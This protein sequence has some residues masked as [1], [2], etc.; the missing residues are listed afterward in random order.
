MESVEKLPLSSVPEILSPR[1]KEKE[2][3]PG[4]GGS[5]ETRWQKRL[6]PFMVV[7]L[8]LVMLF[9]FTASAFQLYYLHQRIERSPELD[10]NP[11]LGILESN[12]AG[13]SEKD[14]LEIGR[15]KTL[16]I[17]EGNALQRRYHQANTL[18]MS[19]IWTAYLGFVTGMILAL[20]GAT[21]ILGK[22]RESESQV[23]AGSQ[24]WK[25]S[26]TTASPGLVLALLGTI[27]MITTMV[28]HYEIKVSDGQLYT[29]G[30]DG[31]ANRE[32]QDQAD[33]LPPPATFP[34]ESEDEVIPTKDAKAKDEKAV[35]SQPKDNSTR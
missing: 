17:L 24:L 25:F 8:S 21:F 23:D 35:E 32:R 4:R 1:L 28:S 33:A 9:F 3:R 6:L 14:K 5:R 19:R 2:K 11:A 7:V 12:P 34:A 20:V 15:W 26:I 30:W 31:A 10:L 27:L 29:A 22:L 18:L 16:S 13:A